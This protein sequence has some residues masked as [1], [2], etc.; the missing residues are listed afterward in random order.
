MSQRFGIVLVAGLSVAGHILFGWWAVIPVAA[1]GALF[2]QGKGWLTGLAGVLLAWAGIVA[3]S[4][5]LA[6]GPTAEMARSVGQLAGGLPPATIPVATLLMGALLGAVSGM[7][8]H[9]VRNI[10]R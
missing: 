8:G 7:L 1:L 3:Y 9:S 5:V 6:T 2:S 10:T 4:F